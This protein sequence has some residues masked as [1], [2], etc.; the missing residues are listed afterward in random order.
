MKQS[1]ATFPIQNI[2]QIY[3]GLYRIYF[4]LKT[5][6]IYSRKFDSPLNPYKLY[7]V[8]PNSIKY[9]TDDK[10]TIW[11]CSVEAGDW[12]KNLRNYNNHSETYETFIQR[13]EKGFD[14]SETTRYQ[15]A[16]DE[17]ESGGSWKGCKSEPELRNRF[18]RYDKLYENV[19]KYGILPQEEL[20]SHESFIKSIQDK[21][22][23]PKEFSEI[24]VDIGRNGE[25]IWRSGSHRLSIAKIL[26]LDSIPVRICRRHLKWQHKREEVWNNSDQYTLYE[27]T[28][29]DLLDLLSTRKDNNQ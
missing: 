23:H 5:F 1:N 21:Q 20:R 26:S 27:V 3:K 22:H 16:L 2:L 28:H 24:T 29:P 7:N 6:A 17:I 15:I 13:F 9:T 25:L 10:D 11:K 4:L 18:E 19:R 14:W 12:D 8:D